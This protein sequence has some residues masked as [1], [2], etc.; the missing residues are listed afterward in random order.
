VDLLVVLPHKGRATDTSVEI[1]LK[2]RPSFPL[3]IIVRT[4]AK[5]RERLS[6][7]DTFIRDILTNGKVLY[8][9]NDGGVGGKGG[10]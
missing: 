6:M 8:E 9:A 1:R 3:D 5:I 7:G 2:A 4:P 10:R